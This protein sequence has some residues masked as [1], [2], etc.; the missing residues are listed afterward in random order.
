VRAA[1]RAGGVVAGGV[2]AGGVVAASLGWVLAAP[3]ADLAVL[4]VTLPVGR[5]LLDGLGVGAVGL[6]V[7]GRLVR[8]GQR[9]DAAQVLA[10]AGRAATV[11]AGVWA[12]VAVVL[13]WLQAAEVT[14][15]SPARVGMRAVLDYLGSFGAGVALLVTALCAVGYGVLA[16]LR[17]RS[18]LMVATAVLGLLPGPVTGHA[19][20]T[21][22][23]P[24]LAVV[25]VAVHVVAVSLWVGGLAALLVLAGARR[26][27]MATALPRFSPI[28]AGA[29]GTVAVSGVVTAIARLGSLA[30]LVD[31][32]YGRVVLAKAA[33]LAVLA[34]LGR[35]VRRRVLPAV[36][37]H[38]G[39]ALVAVAGTE[40]V[41]MGI[42]LGLA[43][44][45][46]RTPLA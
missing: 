4:R 40:L 5:L 38:R 1:R 18:D 41:I 16:S 32:G 20:T 22:A 17:P 23:A 42:A 43:A 12:A 37:A 45:L 21:A 31:T 8:D 10:T 11:L 29:L 27:L 33:A 34:V 44:A 30:P 7:L 25:S 3:G 35:L 14:G 13:L 15:T 6:A 19:G 9:R 26:S 36:R 24:E 46:T 39:S 2:A 28:A